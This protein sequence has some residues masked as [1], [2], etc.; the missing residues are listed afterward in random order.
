ME[1]LTYLEAKSL[2]IDDYN[3][4]VE[5]GF[6][7]EQALAATLEDSILMMKKQEKIYNAV[8][9]SLALICLKQ[10]FIPD[11]ILD[12]LLALRDFPDFRENEINHYNKDKS[13][14]LSLLKNKQYRIDKDENYKMRIDLLFN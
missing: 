12:R 6:T 7:S 13:G 9:L 1:N 3:T 2:V 10:K 11:Y 14:V 4:F 8:I 5:E